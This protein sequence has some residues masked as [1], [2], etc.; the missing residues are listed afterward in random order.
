MRLPII[1]SVDAL[2]NEQD[3]HIPMFYMKHGVSY[4]LQ[5][6]SPLGVAM[7]MK[8]DVTDTALHCKTIHI[9]GQQR[10]GGEFSWLIKALGWKSAV[11]SK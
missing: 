6:D 10:K 4:T 1:G 5:F 7:E 11:H 8:S 9:C 2:F 3:C